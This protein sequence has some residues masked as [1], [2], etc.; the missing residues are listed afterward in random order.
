[1]AC[2]NFTLKMFDPQKNIIYSE[3]FG[4]EAVTEHTHD[5]LEIVLITSGAGIHTVNGTKI[6]LRQND[7]FILPVH[8]PH[9][10]IPLSSTENFKWINFIVNYDL[11]INYCSQIVPNEVLHL[12]ANCEIMNLLNMMIKE[13]HSYSAYS[14]DILFGYVIA[15]IHLY[16][17]NVLAHD[18]F[19]LMNSEIKSAYIARVVK[20]MQ[21]NYHRKIT[22]KELAE[23][24][25]ISVGHLERLFRNEHSTTPIEYLNLYRIQNACNLLI[26]TDYTIQQVGELVGFYDAKFFY[27]TFKKYIGLTPKNYKKAT[28][29]LLSSDDI[30]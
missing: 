20:Y 5:F 24:A 11:I 23:V 28:R 10:L 7:F 13:A 25:N 27:N 15:L 2:R 6:A 14:E 3:S 29:Q 26:H 30:K 8:T 19:S 18:D 9:S 17:K 1:M 4:C 22:V 21:Q 16:K 12:S